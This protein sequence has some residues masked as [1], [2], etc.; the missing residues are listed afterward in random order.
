MVGW[1]A[2]EGWGWGGSVMENIHT[3]NFLKS[4]S[5]HDS[6]D[7]LTRGISTLGLWMYALEWL[8]CLRSSSKVLSAP[9]SQCQQTKG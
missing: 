2:V 9:S 5:A 6:K 7:G 3:Y 1:G 4:I 8:L